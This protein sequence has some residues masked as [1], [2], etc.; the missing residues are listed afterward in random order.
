MRWKKMC[1][2][3]AVTKTRPNRSFNKIPKIKQL[4]LLCLQK[5]TLQLSLTENLSSTKHQGPSLEAEGLRQKFFAPFTEPS[6]NVQPFFL[7][8][9][10]LDP[11][12]MIQK[13][14]LSQ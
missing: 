13:I 2:S 4:S 14:I 1:P 7:F 12:S 9:D 10:C 6:G 8:S 11:C 5:G 3:F